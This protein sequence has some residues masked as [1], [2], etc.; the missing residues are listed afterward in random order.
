MENNYELINHLKLKHVKIIVNRIVSCNTHI[1]NDFE[2]SLVL[3]GTGIIKVNNTS[4]HVKQGDLILINTCDNHSYSTFSEESYKSSS[5]F[6]DSIPVILIFQ[7]SNHFLREYYPNLRNTIFTSGACE[8][9]F[10]QE[11]IIQLKKILLKVAVAYFSEEDYYQL[12]IIS[13]LSKLFK[14]CYEKIPYHLISEEEKEVLKKRNE[15]I[16]RI[17]SYIDEN[18]TSRIRLE[19]IAEMEKITTTHVSHIF[20]DSFG[21]SFQEYINLKRLEESIRLMNNPDKKLIDIAFE[22][23]FSDPKY[24]NKMY[25]KYFNCRPKEFKTHAKIN[26]ESSQQIKSIK[27]EL[28]FDDKRALKTIRD[29]ISE[30]KITL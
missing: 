21:I 19:D 24:M 8:N 17:I 12:T 23:G 29:F 1:H 2:L 25:Q 28:L 15:R 16:Q 6:T 26:F 18:F 7:I 3:K 5:E 22:S 30:Q 4:Y 20:T 14:K 11:E 9:F 27:D 10:S 13:D